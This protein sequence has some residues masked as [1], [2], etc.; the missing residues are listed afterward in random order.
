[1]IS[2]QLPKRGDEG[3]NLI[4]HS[5][6]AVK[7][8]RRGAAILSAAVLLMSAPAEAM[9]DNAPARR[10]VLS[11]SEIMQGNTSAVY[12][13]SYSGSSAIPAGYA[14]S[15]R[16]R[17]T[18]QLTGTPKIITDYLMEDMGLNS[19]AAAGI[20]ANIQSES[21]FDPN[22]VGDG[23]TS[24][25]LCQWK[26]E[27]RTRL[28]NYCSDRALDAS[29]VSAQLEYLNSE[30]T[31][32]YPETL[33]ILRGA[34]NDSSGADNAA[35]FFCTDYEAPADT[36]T[37]LTVRCALAK[38]YYAEVSKF[39]GEASAMARAEAEMITADFLRNEMHFNTAVSAGIMANIFDESG[40]NPGVIGD[41]GSATGICQWT[42]KRLDALDKYCRRHGLDVN[43]IYSQLAFM[44]EELTTEFPGTMALLNK[45]ENTPEGAKQAAYLFCKN[46]EV[47]T[48]L[49]AAVRSR[50]STTTDV[51]YPM[52][53]VPA[54]A[55]ELIAADRATVYAAAKEAAFIGSVCPDSLQQKLLSTGAREIYRAE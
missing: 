38:S 53:S 33:R 15:A 3:D 17:K 19:A 43:E 1:M 35:Y 26:G 41:R 44:K 6:F 32:Y 16:T 13:P 24:Y 28:M 12:T 54:E 9:A 20:L 30:L 11:I 45:C 14:V 47:P 36:A 8:L 23:G 40:F 49:S 48:N 25:G 50:S 34:K 27:R 31:N 52:L 2:W 46:Y 51:Y 4:L 55:A 18:E 10:Q 39:D 22:T 5:P 37:E 29:T 7:T 21:S 42:G